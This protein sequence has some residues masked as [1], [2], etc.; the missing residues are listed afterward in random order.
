MLILK[1]KFRKSQP[2][3]D[4]GLLFKVLG[5]KF[6]NGFA[7]KS[8]DIQGRSRAFYRAQKVNTDVVKVVCS[9]VCPGKDDFRIFLKSRDDLAVQKV[10]M[11]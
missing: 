7:V 9:L 4:L 5:L 3:N 10:C 8:I 1:I 11:T 6:H 2:K